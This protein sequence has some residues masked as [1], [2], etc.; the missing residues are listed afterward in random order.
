MFKP[1]SGHVE[2]D[3][4]KAAIYTIERAIRLAKGTQE[5]VLIVDCT[6]N[7]GLA[8]PLKRARSIAKLFMRHYPQTLAKAV[9]VGST[10][11]QRLAYY[12]FA[13]VLPRTVRKKVLFH[14]T[15]VRGSIDWKVPPYNLDQG[16]MHEDIGGNYSF[17]FDL[18]EYMNERPWEADE[19]SVLETISSDTLEEPE[20]EYVEPIVRKIREELTLVCD[21]PRHPMF[22]AF[23]SRFNR[24]NAAARRL[25]S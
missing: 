11:R 13:S 12:L 4:E 9:V 7:E 22:E 3:L 6:K 24:T 1:F 8:V 25:A 23:E 2:G 16:L 14:H 10:F 17:P 18:A 21:P 5:I 15:N 20:E 19:R